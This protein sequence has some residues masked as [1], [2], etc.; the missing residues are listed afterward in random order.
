MGNTFHR[1][2]SHADEICASVVDLY[3]KTFEISKVNDARKYLL[4]QSNRQIEQIPPSYPTLPF[5][6][7][8]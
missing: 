8:N 5:C 7:Q 1:L 2:T 3:C 4:C 6:F